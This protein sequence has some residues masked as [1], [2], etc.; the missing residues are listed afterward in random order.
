MTVFVV[1][2]P[3]KK[4]NILSA[5]EYGELDFILSETENIMYTPVSTISRINPTL[6]N[7]SEEDYLLLI[8]DPVAI[9]VAVHF[10]LLL[11]GNKA[12]ILKWD[13]REYKY[14]SMKL[15]T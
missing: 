15:E 5:T 12:K 9:G 8:G 10:A 14:Y 1:Q 11:N 7:F 13:N 4:K 3:D 6:R 2:K